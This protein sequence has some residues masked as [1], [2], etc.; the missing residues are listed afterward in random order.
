MALGQAAGTAAGMA[1]QENSGLRSIDVPKLQ[2][3]LQENGVNLGKTG[4]VNE[5]SYRNFPVGCR[6]FD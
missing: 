2:A 5:R 6:L 4:D 3:I 1:V